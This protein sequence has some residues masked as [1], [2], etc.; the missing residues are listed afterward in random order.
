M[1]KVTN[2]K[3]KLPAATKIRWADIVDTPEVVIDLDVVEQNLENCQ[4]QCDRLGFAAHPHIKTHKLPLLAFAQ[5]EAGAK[6]ITC[7]KIGEAEVMADAGI[8]DILIS[9]NV[10]GEQKIRR[11]LALSKRANLTVCADSRAVVA[12]LARIFKNKARPLKVL[13]ECDTGMHRCGVVSAEQAV[14]LAK[15][16]AATSGLHFEGLMSYPAAGGGNTALDWLADAKQACL[17][18]GLKV[19]VVSTG[20]TPDLY[21]LN[22]NSDITQY[23]PG[24]Y[25]Y[26][27]RSL[28]AA[29]ACGIEDCALSVIT[30]VVSCPDAQ[31][32]M[33]DAGSKSLSSDLFGLDGH[34][35]VVGH[36]KITIPALSEEHGHLA[37]NQKSKTAKLKVGN[38]LR[39]IPNHACVVSNLFDQVT[40][41]RGDY[42]VSRQAVLAR[43]KTQ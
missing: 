33:V 40:L 37:T 28:I 39:I 24:S 9:Y 22:T 17:R 16:I 42:F 4:E 43:G 6:G 19:A 35:L 8:E 36:P 31:R 27:D 7:Q 1:L 32:V 5:L 38:I 15:K 29:G 12:G 13:V 25:I 2:M 3:Y 11:L 26:N 14:A 23:R 30:T 10:I 34:G 20:G 21:N 18:A 41:V